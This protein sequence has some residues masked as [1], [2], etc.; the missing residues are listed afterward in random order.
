V[1]ER[2]EALLI[3]SLR[4]AVPL[5]I[6]EIRDWTPQ[7]RDNDACWYR[8]L[9][10]ERGGGDTLMYGGGRPGEVAVT[11]RNLVHA[12]A[13]LAYQPGGVTFSGVHWCADRRRDL[14]RDVNGGGV[15]WWRTPG[16]G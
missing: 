10:V 6:M 2:N 3:D 14:V 15:L 11:F 5:R 9:L 12:L 16:P 8:Q 4:L 7:Q 13:A 1:N